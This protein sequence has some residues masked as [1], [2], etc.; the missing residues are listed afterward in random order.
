MVATKSGKAGAKRKVAFATAAGDAAA[1]SVATTVVARKAPA[2][3]KKPA[4]STKAKE[5]AGVVVAA[6]KKSAAAK[7]AAKEAT[8][9]GGSATGERYAVIELRHLPAEFQEPQ[10]TKFM[11]Q[12]GSKVTRCVCLRH[13]K[14]RSSKGIAYVRFEDPSAIPVALDEC[15]GMLL[16]GRTVRAKKAMLTRPLPDARKAA[17]RRIFDFRRRTRGPP[18]QR[19]S[20]TIARELSHKRR[21]AKA[22]ASAAEAAAGGDSA[23]AQAKREST[24]AALE[25][26]SASGAN[27]WIGKLKKFAAAEAA[28]NA[29][30]Q[31]M[32]VPYAFDGFGVQFRRVP[33]ALLVK[34][35][36]G[37][38]VAASATEKGKKAA[39]RSAKKAAVARRRS[40]APA[41]HR[42]EEGPKTAAKSAAKAVEASKQR[43]AAA[44]AAGIVLSAASPKK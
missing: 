28:R 30:F 44:V 18:L 20:S 14:T 29:I 13:R 26:L 17:R 41:P 9:G 21:L 8:I 39:G 6:T 37:A 7:E 43:A 23:E 38:A 1:K 42:Q 5:R 36:R 2:G 19:F 10:I 16:G 40:G 35:K 15:D 25:K 12:F 34:P 27:A 4:P 22:V 3:S 33:Q 24:A 11:N 31:K 32:G